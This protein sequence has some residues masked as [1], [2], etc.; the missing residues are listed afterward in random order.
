MLHSLFTNNPNRTFKVFI[1]HTNIKP[2]DIHSLEQ[3]VNKNGSELFNIQ[4]DGQH[5]DHAPILM[6]YTKEMYYRLLAFKFLPKELDRILYLD[7]DMLVLNP[8][9]QLYE[10]DMGKHLFAAASHEKISLKEINRI[11]LLP[12]EIDAYYNSGVLLM[13]LKEQRK[14]I[15]EDRIFKFVEENKKK[16][17]LP[18]Q[19]ILNALYS[20]Y[21]WSLEETIYN[22]DARYY[23]YYKLLSNHKIDM[24]YVI[25]HTVFLHFCG[26]KKPWKSN[27]SGRFHALY[28][29][30][31]K[32]ALRETYGTGQELLQPAS[33][34]PVRITCT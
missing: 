12:Y 11:R 5:F 20:K 29:H 3:F 33:V 14:V 19:D 32:K 6:H 13:N 22:Y 4:V 21:I 17:I 18:D 28:K 10:M 31:E 9:D 27:Y 24:D 7:P 15:K 16:L 30:Y 25:N 26:K 2:K 1:M 34:S 23:N 8:I